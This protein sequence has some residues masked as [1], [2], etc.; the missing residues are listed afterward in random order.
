MWF[1]FCSNL[2]GKCSSCHSYRMAHPSPFIPE[3]PCEEPILWPSVSTQ[4][5][6]VQVPVFWNWFVP[7]PSLLWHLPMASRKKPYLF[8]YSPKSFSGSKSTELSIYI[9]DCF[10]LLS[11]V[12]LYWILYVA[13]HVLNFFLLSA[14]HP[15]MHPPPHQLF[16][17]AI[18]NL[19]SSF[20]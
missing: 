17:W 3:C 2:G 10:L 15:G 7:Y 13:L 11:E 20:P 6:D 18:F 5:D 12:R 16:T 4:V 19:S 9:N 8:H 14:P 1:P